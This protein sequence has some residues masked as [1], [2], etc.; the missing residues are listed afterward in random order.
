MV[1]CGQEA[2]LSVLQGEGRPQTYVQEPVSLYGVGHIVDSMVMYV[3]CA[4]LVC[5]RSEWLDSV[6][7]VAVALPLTI[8]KLGKTPPPLWADVGFGAVPR[9]VVPCNWIH[10]S[11]TV[12]HPQT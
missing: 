10:G 6:V 2:D 4:L 11:R 1:Y 5:V 3:T 8:V 9:G 12:S 7:Y